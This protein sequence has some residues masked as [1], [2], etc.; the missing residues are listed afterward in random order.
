MVRYGRRDKGAGGQGRERKSLTGEDGDMVG[1]TGKG[2][3]SRSE[4]SG[5]SCHWS[6]G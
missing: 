6:I 5:H 3:S 4:L 1:G 2:V